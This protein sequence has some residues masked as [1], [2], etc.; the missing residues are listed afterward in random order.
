MEVLHAVCCGLDV[1]V[2]LV[3][4]CLRSTGPKGSATFERRS[5][6]TT[7]K[8]LL[9]LLEWLRERGCTTVAME[10]TGVY[11]KPVYHIL[12]GAVDVV[13]G[14]AHEIRQRPGRKTDKADAEWIAE[15]LAHDLIR[16][17]YVPPP[18]IASLRDLTR[19]RVGMVQVRSQAKNRVHKLLQD[20]NIKL[21]S[22]A[23]DVFGVSGR[24][25]VDALVSGERNPHRLAELAR[26]TL[27]RK[28]PQ[29]QEALDGRFTEHHAALVRMQLDLLD[30]LEQ[31]IADIDRRIE[32]LL[33]PLADEIAL[34]ATIPGV[35]HT[36]AAAVIGEIGTDM[37]RF[38]SDDRLASWAGVCP[39]NNE[40]AGKR[41]SGKTRKGNRYLRR[42]L[43]QCAW[44]TRDTNTF[45]GRT[46]RRFQ[47][48]IGGKKA[49]MAVAHKILVIVYHVLSTGSGYDEARYDRPTPRQEDRQRNAAIRTLERL[50]YAVDLRKLSPEVTVANA[51]DA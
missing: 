34:V 41:R 22:V 14:N 17:S 11:W 3:E 15:L 30:L 27:R 20:A 48:R 9:A 36:A 18:A 51:P 12:S 29:L 47:A 44:A 26:G 4:A 40:T 46:F 25:M 19:T 28:V 45:L 33:Q 49:A 39:G 21:S 1:H 2:A 10:S 7:T 24:A 5:F 32:V 37:S 6:G 38:G 42:V 23:S 35:D 31:H 16:P 8:E 50:G 13:L 43:V